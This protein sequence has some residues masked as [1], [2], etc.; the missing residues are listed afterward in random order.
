MVVRTTG[1]SLSSTHSASTAAGI[2]SASPVGA[3]IT[4]AA[5]ASTLAWRRTRAAA[6]SS[7]LC[8][9]FA[10]AP[11]RFGFGARAI[12]SCT[13]DSGI[14]RSSPARQLAASARTSSWASP[15]LLSS[16]LTPRSRSAPCT[17]MAWAASRTTWRPAARTRQLPAAPTTA[18]AAHNTLSATDT[19]WSVV[20]A[21]S[22][23]TFP[24]CA[25]SRSESSWTASMSGRADWRRPAHEELW[26]RREL[27][28]KK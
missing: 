14:A 9:A 1:S 26:P 3:L 23:A 22:S 19:C 20:P 18:S 8:S 15:M 4:A 25:N 27:W 28:M 2:H 21:S 10:F 17:T 12:S 7:A 16:S 6:L 24:T 13:C 11:L 5:T